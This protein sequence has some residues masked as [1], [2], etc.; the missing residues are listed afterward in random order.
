MTLAEQAKKHFDKQDL[1]PDLG[2]RTQE[3]F[4]PGTAHIFPD[5]S[6]AVHFDDGAFLVAELQ[7]NDDD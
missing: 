1:I 4:G 2:Q 3:S 5:G 6:L 7:E